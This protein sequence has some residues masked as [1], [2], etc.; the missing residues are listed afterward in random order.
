MMQ[1]KVTAEGEKEAEMYDKYVCWCKS[2]AGA[3]AKSIA[4]AEAK[5][6]ELLAEIE[7]SESRKVQLEEDVK[8]HK[9]DREA[10]K[11]SMKEATAIREKEA[12]AYA[13]ETA[14][15]QANIDAIKRAVAAISA[16]MGSGFLQTDSAQVLRKLLKAGRVEVEDADR[17][18]L[19]AFLSAG[20]S[21]AY[22]PQSG[23]IVGILK[24]M[25]DEMAADIADVKAT[26]EAAVKAYE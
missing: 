20:A 26:E 3:L 2:G 9:A 25:G 15:T 21:N 1:N 22:A 11:A 16:G 23:Q 8:Q 24:Q 6:P 17:D 7:A 18:S 14:E 5:I 4:D 10:A 13:K 12:A 19:T